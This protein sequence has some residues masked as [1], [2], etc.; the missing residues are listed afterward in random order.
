MDMN[1]IKSMH[2]PTRVLLLSLAL[3]CLSTPVSAFIFY[4]EAIEAKVIDAQ[5]GKPVQ[6]AIV[7]ANWQLEGGVDSGIPRAQLEILETVTDANGKFTVPAWGPRLAFRGHASFKWPQILVFKS[8]YKYVRL[9][10]EPRSGSQFTTSSDWNA[11]TIKF[12]PFGKD[13]AAY[14]RDF[15]AL[16]AQLD[17][18][19]TNGGDDCAW[20]RLPQAL[21]FVSRE[22]IR[23]RAIGMKDFGSLVSNLRANDAYFKSKGC[24]SPIEFIEGLESR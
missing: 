12:L 4:A 13:T 10:N 8:G 14:V 15:D 5:T 3:L 19:A 7:T 1:P 17:Q 2:F 18:I 21:R 22:E 6:G 20:R 24:G 23:I 9:T 11:K 16:N